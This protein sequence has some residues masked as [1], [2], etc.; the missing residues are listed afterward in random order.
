MSFIFEQDQLEDY[1]TAK[2][3]FSKSECEQIIKYANLK[4]KNNAE[5]CLNN[6]ITIDSSIRQTKLV[7]I[8]L[9]D[10][11]TYEMHELFKRFGS[12]AYH[13]NEQFFKFDLFGFSEDFQFCE[14]N[15]PNDKYDWHMDK[16]F[17]K[18]IRKLSLTLQLNDPNEYE[19]GNFEIMTGKNFETIK[20]E[21][22][23]VIVFPSY[24]LHRVTEITKGKRNSL[25]GWASGKPFK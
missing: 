16:V 4:Q 14:Y 6:K 19:G 20:L 23:E 12:V 25:V 15:A 21:Q 22:G 1:V 8:S 7:W 9:E 3:V 2:K 10:C 18:G 24:I 13:L 17:G 5:I 11:E